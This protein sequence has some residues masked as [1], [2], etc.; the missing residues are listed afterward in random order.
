MEIE[1]SLVSASR[2]SYA[3]IVSCKSLGLSSIRCS[4]EISSPIN[5]NLTLEIW[6]TRR[7]QVNSVL[8][9][10]AEVI[11]NKLF[12]VCTVKEV[13]PIFWQAVY[14]YIYAFA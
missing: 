14:A 9:I 6:R 13:V 3:H 11:V 4:T 8:L 7:D 1:N 10:S 12:E 5:N 2:Y